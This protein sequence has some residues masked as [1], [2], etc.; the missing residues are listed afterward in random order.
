MHY[1]TL[2][3]LQ[4]EYHDVSQISLYLYYICC[5]KEAWAYEAGCNKHLNTIILLL[6]KNT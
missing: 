2:G 5:F 6:K 1:Q 3:C 4:Q